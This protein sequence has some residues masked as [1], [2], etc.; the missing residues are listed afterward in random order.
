MADIID[1]TASSRYEWDIEGQVAFAD[2]R[3]QGNQRLIT[4]VEVPEALRNRGIAAKLMGF[5]IED[6]K[7]QGFTLVPI[8]SYAVAYLQRH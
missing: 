7:A 3:K 6:S 4:H 5:I 8:C 2:Y 1:N